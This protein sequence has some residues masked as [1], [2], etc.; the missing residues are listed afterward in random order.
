MPNKELG[1]TAVGFFL[2][3]SNFLRILDTHLP[4]FFSS[5]QADFNNKQP[6]SQVN[7]NT[8]VQLSYYCFVTI[9]AQERK[10]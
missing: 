9:L 10:D 5:F 7:K 1:S 3:N 4:Y 8:Y 2:W 6:G